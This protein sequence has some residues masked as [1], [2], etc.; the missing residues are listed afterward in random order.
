MAGG[1]GALDFAAVDGDDL[2]QL[3]ERVVGGLFEGA[4]AVL[5]DDLADD[6]AGLGRVGWRPCADARAEARGSHQGALL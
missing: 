6:E 1:F 5:G 4:D 2:A 3:D